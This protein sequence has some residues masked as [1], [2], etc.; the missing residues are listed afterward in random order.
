MRRS[1]TAREITAMT[2]LHEAAFEGLTDKIK[3]KISLGAD[4]NSKNED[5]ET[6][7]YWAAFNGHIKA[8]EALISLGADVNTANEK[9]LTPLHDASCFSGQIETV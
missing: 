3:H 7:L 2:T 4:V 1:T 6:P 5:G 8:V 9:G